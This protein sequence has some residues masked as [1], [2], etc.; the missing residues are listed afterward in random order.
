[1]TNKFTLRQ[2]KE[3]LVFDINSSIFCIEDFDFLLMTVKKCGL[4]K[5]ILINMYNI[6]YFDN[7]F[8]DY[9]IKLSSENDDLDLCFYNLNPIINLLFYT[10]NLDKHFEIYVNE[11]DSVC[12]I[13]PLVKRRL[14]LVS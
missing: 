13:N 4:S 12:K 6:D 7:E 9:F 10:F 8:V 14:K 11:H 2:L 1:V 3:F 5:K